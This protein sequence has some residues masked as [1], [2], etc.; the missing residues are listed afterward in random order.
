MSL[1]PENPIAIAQV[2]W[3]RSILVFKTL[4]ISIFQQYSA[5]MQ[6]LLQSE[7]IATN[8]NWI[9]TGLQN[10]KTYNSCCFDCASTLMVETMS[11]NRFPSLI[12]ASA[13]SALIL[14][15]QTQSPYN[16]D[17]LC[18]IA[19][20]CVGLWNMLA[21]LIALGCYRIGW[22]AWGLQRI[23]DTQSTLQSKKSPYNP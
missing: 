16:L 12:T 22:V 9:A 23:A 2:S 21:I 18:W 4:L 1:Q 7:R 14:Q 6:I 19:L 8:K 20:D 15:T 11:G 3:S 13:C 5:I 10:M 17:R